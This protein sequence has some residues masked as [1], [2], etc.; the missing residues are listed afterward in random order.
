[1]SSFRRF[2]GPGVLLILLAACAITASFL[3]D[4][5][6]ERLVLEW[7]GGHWS[8]LPGVALLS[9]YGDW[10]ELMLLGP[11]ELA[12]AAMKAIPDARCA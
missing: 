10:P 8:R 5:T 2:L 4:A 7:N 6:V 3:L 1:M 9:R 12:A 11:A